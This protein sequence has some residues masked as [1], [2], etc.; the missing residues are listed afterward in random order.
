MAI[1]EWIEQNPKL[2]AAIILGG[3]ALG[4]FLAIVGTLVL[5]FAGLAQGWGALTPIIAAFGKV[6]AGL[7]TGTILIVI[8]ALVLAIIF[9]KEAWENNLGG[10]QDYVQRWAKDIIQILGLLWEGFKL[11]FGGIGDMLQAVMTG[12]LELFLTGLKSF[13]SGIWLIFKTLW[14]GLGKMIGDAFIT[15]YRMFI[16]FKSG[17]EM[18]FLEMGLKLA[19][20]LVQ[21]I[22]WA[23]DKINAF[24]AKI[25]GGK[26]LQLPSVQGMITKGF[27]KKMGE[28]GES[29]TSAEVFQSNFNDK[30]QSL[31]DSL[32]QTVLDSATI[33]DP[34]ATETRAKENNEDVVV[35]LS[36]ITELLTAISQ[37][38]SSSSFYT[39]EG[40]GISILEEIKR[41]TG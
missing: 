36:K 7:S 33:G 9:L 31:L 4:T 24:V 17:V 21:P 16:D 11:A 15:M 6:L 1:A 35:E 34:V 20:Y 14:F 25:P 40:E 3:A 8:G 12:D 41:L 19:R 13:A 18:L 32:K 39:Q 27:M 38:D 29:S 26:H 37:G 5:A 22:Q 2:V 23:V 30:M 10:I 28:S